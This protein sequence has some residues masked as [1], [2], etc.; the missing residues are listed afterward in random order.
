MKKVICL[1]FVMFVSVTAS[2]QYIYCPGDREY[3]MVAFMESEDSF[4]WAGLIDDDV[5]HTKI[6]ARPA[7]VYACAEKDIISDAVVGGARG[8]VQTKNIY[9]F[10][11]EELYKPLIIDSTFKCFCNLNKGLLNG[12]KTLIYIKE[13]GYFYYYTKN[14]CNF[15]TVT[16][17]YE[18]SEKIDGPHCFTAGTKILTPAGETNIEALKVGDEVLSYDHK[19][20]AVATV[21]I[22]KTF[23]HTNKNYG[24][25]SL[26]NGTK[27][28]VTAEHRFYSVDKKKYIRADKLSVNEKL[29]LNKENKTETVTVVSYTKAV[30]KA[31]V[32]NINVKP[33]HNYF[34]NGVLVHNIK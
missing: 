21:K 8:L 19:A 17:S 15:G 28:L 20:N 18:K 34:A 33:F 7:T 11:L 23:K 22:N 12:C 29:M 24:E 27:L 13:D 4:P 14:V 10:D 1:L 31:D 3:R 9:T 26:S 16:T 5:V 25:L 6:P 30:G 32:Y 2:A